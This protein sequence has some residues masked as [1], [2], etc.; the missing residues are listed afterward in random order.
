MG[1]LRHTA[2]NHQ[3]RHPDTSVRFSVSR[4]SLIPTDAVPEAAEGR[5]PSRPRGHHVHRDQHRGQ[6][7]DSER[8]GEAV[9][10]PGLPRAIINEFIKSW[11]AASAHT[12]L[13][14]EYQIASKSEIL[15]LGFE[16]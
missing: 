14:Q 10:T 6:R 12:S 1:S 9:R 7:P 5:Q 2:E 13:R 15:K 4:A 8:D 11:E 3:F 16:S